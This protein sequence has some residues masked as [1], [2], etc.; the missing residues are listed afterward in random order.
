M[1]DRRADSESRERIAVLE[2]Q[3]NAMLKQHADMAKDIRSILA[4]LSEAKGG[5][6]MLLLVGG[7][8]GA[9]GAYLTKWAAALSQTLPR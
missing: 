3:M 9:V 6:K 8:G 4:T 2:T 1:D 5:W 7:A